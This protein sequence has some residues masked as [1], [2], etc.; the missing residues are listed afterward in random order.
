M[1]RKVSKLIAMS[2]GAALAW[3][4]DPVSGAERR[5][6]VA[7]QVS[8]LTGGGVGSPNDPTGGGAAPFPTAAP[9]PQFG[10][11]AQTPASTPASAA[12]PVAPAD[13]DSVADE[14]RANLR[15]NW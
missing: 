3:F 5:R 11:T 14:S 15:T 1:Q 2:T 7:D 9:P 12:A 13:A 10:G 4:L 6:Q 8:G